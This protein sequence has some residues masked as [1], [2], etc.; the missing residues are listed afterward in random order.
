M[1]GWEMP[2]ARREQGKLQRRKQARVEDT[3]P[4]RWEE[5]WDGGKLLVEALV[6][7]GSETKRNG[8]PR[9]VT[10]LEAGEQPALPMAGALQEGYRERSS[11]Q[12]LLSAGV[13]RGHAQPAPTL[14]VQPLCLTLLLLF[15]SLGW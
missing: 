9:D 13:Q 7:I 4:G 3:H 8:D 10:R 12:P 6:V 11:L 14:S 5:S 1:L 15:C 2:G